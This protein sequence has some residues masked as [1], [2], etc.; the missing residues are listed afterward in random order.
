MWYLSW[1]HFGVAL[2]LG[3]IL[4]LLRWIVVISQGERN[5]FNR[6]QHSYH[7]DVVA[8]FSVKGCWK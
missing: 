6:E 1:V 3:L 8:V 2:G 4:I 5:A 7:P